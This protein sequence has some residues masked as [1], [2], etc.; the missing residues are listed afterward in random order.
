MGDEDD[1]ALLL[2]LQAY[3]LALHL[4]TDQRIER[5]EGFV[6][7]QDGRVVGQR[8]GQADALLHA[9]GQ[10]VRVAVF[11]AG[12]AHLAQR[13]AGTG[14]ALA[15]ADAGDFQAEGGVFQDAHVWHQR[16]GLKHHAHLLA[17]HIEQRLVGEAGDLAPVQVDAARSGFD[18][19]VE[20]PH[21]GG[22]AR[23]GQPHDHEDLTAL[24]R[25]AGVEHADHMTRLAE[26]FVL[27][28]TFAQH[29]HGD[30][31]MGP[32]Y[33]EDVLHRKNLIGL[34]HTT[35]ILMLITR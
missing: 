20:Q 19:A 32:E 4:A 12:E 6:H 24:D 21:H 33:L 15:L 8:A 17:A 31:R 7:E 23:A 27:V 28:G 13:F 3:Q 1:G 9:A 2:R 29:L 22:L 26:Y 34:A 16:E 11:V 18:Q 35:L 30:I 5:G 25:E 14:I 10:L